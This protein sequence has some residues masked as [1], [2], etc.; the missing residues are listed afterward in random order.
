MKM[1]GGKM[2]NDCRPKNEE[3][4]S[5]RERVL[6]GLTKKEETIEEG[7]ELTRMVMSISLVS[8]GELSL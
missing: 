3:V 4:Q 6:T 5:E 2:V 8:P 7:P 1:K